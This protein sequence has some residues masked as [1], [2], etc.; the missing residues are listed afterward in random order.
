MHTH[1]PAD[2]SAAD[3]AAASRT[4][5]TFGDDVYLL[6]EQYRPFVAGQVAQA[7]YPAQGRA[8]VMV[9]AVVIV[10]G[11]VVG[12]LATVLPQM[13]E[14]SALDEHGIDTTGEIVQTFTGANSAG[15]TAYYVD[16]AFIVP[17]IEHTFTGR[18][19]VG[20]DDFPNWEMGQAV[21]VRYLPDDPSRSKLVTGDDD[22][23]LASIAGIGMA[24]IMLGGLAIMV[25]RMVWGWQ[26][27]RKLFAEGRL[28]PGSIA[29]IRWG[30]D[31]DGDPELRVTFS[32]VAPDGKLVRKR[33]K[34]L[35]I[36]QQGES[37]PP[38]GTP[39]AVLYL[40]RRTFRML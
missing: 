14:P 31:S 16:Y 29:K 32:F 11:V 27:E 6:D 15:N 34:K 39:V 5:P 4:G 24:V 22:S 30:K 28:L 3:S 20:R 23:P 18:Q 36:S 1:S 21:T 10:V 26:Q 25:L 2:L 8:L 17:G 37:L 33:Q 7:P 38:E 13:N 12:F 40:N 35:A 9:I 19:T